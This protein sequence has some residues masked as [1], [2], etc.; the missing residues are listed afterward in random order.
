M[1]G[2]VSIRLYILYRAIS[3]YLVLYVINRRFAYIDLIACAVKPQPRLG[4]CEVIHSCTRHGLWVTHLLCVGAVESTAGG[5]SA[6]G[7]AEQKKDLYGD[8]NKLKII[9]PS[10]AV[11]LLSVYRRLFSTSHRNEP[12]IIGDDAIGRYYYYQIVCRL[13]YPNASPPC[14]PSRLIRCVTAHTRARP[15]WA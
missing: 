11:I 3:I 1:I 10:G 7:K 14:L 9:P 15:P 2:L 6:V 13:W 5:D 4:P 8:R 12:S